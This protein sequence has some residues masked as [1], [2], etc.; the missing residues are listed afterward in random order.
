MTPTKHPCRASPGCFRGTL[1]PRGAWYAYTSINLGREPEPMAESLSP[2]LKLKSSAD[3]CSR[4]PTDA[5]SVMLLHAA[6]SV[7][8]ELGFVRMHG[9]QDLLRRST[10][11]DYPVTPAGYNT[12]SLSAARAAG[13]PQVHPTH[14][15]S[16]VGQSVLGRAVL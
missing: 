6:V 3:D 12:R 1:Q 13:R 10:S 14:P 15:L 9:P 2:K 5:T 7:H 4:P 16:R 11:D 8:P